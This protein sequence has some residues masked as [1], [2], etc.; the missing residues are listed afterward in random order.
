MART[1]MPNFNSNADLPSLKSRMRDFKSAGEK[2]STPFTASTRKLAS[3]TEGEVSVGSLRS[4]HNWRRL[5]SASVLLGP[6]PPSPT[7]PR[8]LTSAPSFSS[9]SSYSLSRADT[10]CGPDGCQETRSRG[11]GYT[12][13]A[14]AVGWR[15][16]TVTLAVV[17][18]QRP[19]PLK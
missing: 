5:S 13:V 2:F 7:T 1:S 11:G 17:G 16:E 18:P 10:W 3:S 19:T 12:I 9:S 4:A 8:P 15:C 14:P 6:L